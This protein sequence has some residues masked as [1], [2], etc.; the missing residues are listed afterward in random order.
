MGFTC[1][2]RLHCKI[3]QM[4]FFFGLHFITT[5]DMCGYVIS[6]YIHGPQ[7]PEI[8]EMSIRPTGKACPCGQTAQVSAD[9][10]E[11]DLRSSPEIDAFWMA[12]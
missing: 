12:M 6:C 11:F 1:D 10:A 4:R 2:I 8:I 9:F 7:H 5:V 3:L